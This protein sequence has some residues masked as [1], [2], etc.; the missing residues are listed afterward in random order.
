MA[1]RWLGMALILSLSFSADAARGQA[2]EETFP[3]TAFVNVE[4]AYYRS[5]PGASYYPTGKLPYGEQVEVYRH[6]RGGWYAVRPPLGS[7]S[8]VAARHLKQTEG[9][10]GM[11]MEEDV[12]AGVGSSFSDI[13]E[14]Q[15]VRLDRGEEVEILESVTVGDGP[16][17]EV[18]HKIAPPAGEFRWIARNHLSLDPPP[19]PSAQRTGRRNLL[20]D[21]EPTT[22]AP[23][24]RG[25][26]HRAA[27]EL[28]ADFEE[29][30]DELAQSLPAQAGRTSLVDGWLKSHRK[31]LTDET[32]EASTVAERRATTSVPASSASTIG[33]ELDLV[34]LELSHM[35]AEEPSAWSFD[36]LL[37]RAET[38]LTRTSEP[39]ERRRARTL[40]QR[41][42]NFE[43]IKL[44]HA[45][46]SARQYEQIARAEWT[47]TDPS[48]SN[49]TRQPAADGPLAGNA[50]ARNGNDAAQPGPSSRRISQPATVAQPVAAKIPASAAAATSTAPAKPPV[51]SAPTADDRFD[52]I[53]K[54]TRVVS[55]KAGMPQY[56]L[57]D[58][59]GAVRQYVTSAP[60]VNLRRYIGHQVGITG[61]KG[62]L[63]ELGAHHVTAK[64]VTALD[65]KVLR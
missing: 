10:L 31:R 29:A 7:F 54:L 14:V 27:D 65:G 9:H 24:L 23:P 33:H 21:D 12:T 34:N 57:M 3:Y 61:M 11:V 37:G 38:A 63:P 8:W 50:S 45:N 15:Q 42:R 26:A 25:A 19:P 55:Q 47:S 59:A 1:A 16:A 56:A 49:A 62:Y 28:S 35:V 53:G 4:G 36:E 32:G 20:I 40:V 48:Q 64:R 30:A 43:E 46:L 44:R 17:A 52:G 18:W 6:D 41:I 51:V 22:S 2:E 5:G 39:D 58:E 13:R 60:G